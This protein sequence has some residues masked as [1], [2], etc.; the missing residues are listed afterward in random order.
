MAVLSNKRP[1]VWE[2]FQP[3]QLPLG[4]CLWAGDVRV[5]EL[6]GS[7]L[8]E[9]PGVAGIIALTQQDPAI[10]PRPED[11][12]RIRTLDYIETA[13]VVVDGTFAEFW[14]RRGKNLRHN[15]KRQHARL[16][17]EKRLVQLEVI[18]SA[19]EVPAAV[20]DY[21]RL[22]SAGW[23]SAGGTA[24]DIDNAQGRFYEKV[25]R[26]FCSAGKG[27]I[28]RYRIDGKVVAMDLCIEDNGVVVV[29]KTAYDETVP[30][31]SPATLMRHE[32]F[33]RLFA[34]GTVGRIEF[35]GKVMEWHRRWTE[36]IRMLYHV[37]YYRSLWI[38]KAHELLTRASAREST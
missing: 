3:S 4:A 22:E 19:A 33:D 21:G 32:Y 23:K 14:A 24:V 29:L 15:V 27:R 16:E 5:D 25:F 28:Y 13:R 31:I 12:P 9:L 17:N 20:E 7:L 35:Y 26:S 38:R 8:A 18:D 36:D 10:C 1:G 11:A 37:N 30:N 6:L 34:E 2:T